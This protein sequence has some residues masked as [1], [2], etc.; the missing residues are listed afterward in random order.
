MG[1][2]PLKS[3]TSS[4]SPLSLKKRIRVAVHTA[5]TGRRGTLERAICVT[6]SDGGM[7]ILLSE[8]I[9]IF[10][11]FKFLKIFMYWEIYLVVSNLF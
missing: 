11:V 5:R 9:D 4:F 1:V 8:K 3:S 7:T 10:R 2:R 6:T